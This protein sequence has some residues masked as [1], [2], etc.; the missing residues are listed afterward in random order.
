MFKKKAFF[1]T[2]EGIEGSGK[3]YQ[4]QKLYANIKKKNISARTEASKRIVTVI[5]DFT[6]LLIIERVQAINQQLINWA[7][8]QNF[9]LFCNFNFLSSCMFIFN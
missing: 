3:S 1:V 5:L 7:T 4:C 8:R 6:F 2:F 9:F